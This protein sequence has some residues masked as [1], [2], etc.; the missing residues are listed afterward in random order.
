MH[1]VDCLLAA[2]GGQEEWAK[3]L[4]QLRERLAQPRELAYLAKGELAGAG[5][6][7]RGNGFNCD[8]ADSLGPSRD[9]RSPDL[10]L[11]HDLLITSGLDGIFPPGLD[12]AWISRVEP[13]HEGSISYELDARPMAPQ[14]NHLETVF[15]LP[16]LRYGN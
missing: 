6:L 13:L 16:P 2:V 9:L 11:P 1:H 15:V 5:T 7:L 10:L 8:F 14:L 3:P 12:V 4:A